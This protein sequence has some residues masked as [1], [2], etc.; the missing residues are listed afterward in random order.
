MPPAQRADIEA[1]MKKEFQGR[2]VED[3]L[4]DVLNSL[5]TSNRNDAYTA[6]EVVSRFVKSGGEVP[7]DCGELEGAAAAVT[8]AL[9][10]RKAP[11]DAEGAEAPLCGV[12]DVAAQLE[13]T[14]WAGF[15]FSAAEV[16]ALA[17][18]FRHLASKENVVK[19]RFWGKI[20]GTKADYYV[21]E[22]KGGEEEEAAEGVEPPGLTGVNFYTYWVTTSLYALETDWVKLPLA[23]AEHIKASRK[24]KKVVTGNLEAPVITHPHFPGLEKHLLRAQIADIS[25][26][27]I[28]APNGYYRLDGDGAPVEVEIG[29]EEGMFQFPLAKKLLSTDAWIHARENILLSGRTTKPVEPEGEGEGDGDAE[30]AKRAYEEELRLDPWVPPIQEISKNSLPEGFSAVWSISQLYDPT[31]RVVTVLSEGAEG[32]VV[33]TT[34]TS[35]YGVTAVKSLLWPGAVCVSQGTE[36]VNLYVGYGHKVGTYF[37]VAPPPVLD[38]PEDP[39]EQPE[40]TPLEEEPEVEQGEVE[41]E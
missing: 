35:S 30:A 8:K 5:I 19:V 6:F 12:P 18:S 25:A 11:V 26:S 20:L 15:G 32:D 1:L 22:G 21:A 39:E 41:G 27:T 28:L 31:E 36:F 7:F 40:P 37:P 10:V 9:D 17:N 24:V 4:L 23:T 29:K 34:Q 2:T 13:L 14:K 38:E 3:H 33:M 16:D